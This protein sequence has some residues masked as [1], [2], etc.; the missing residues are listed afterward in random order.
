MKNVNTMSAAF[1]ATYPPRK[2]GIGTFTNDLVQ[3]LTH[4]SEIGAAREDHLKVIAMNDVA[5]GY[6]FPSEVNFV[7]REQ[8]KSDYL[9][10]A[11]FLNLS[12]VD[13]VSLQHEYGIFGGDDGSH[14]AYFLNNLRKPV[15]S[16]LHTML[17]KPSSGQKEILEA[18]ISMSTF[19]IVLANKA[20]EILTHVYNVPEEKIVMIPHGAPDVPFLDSSYYKDN[21]Q[22]ED[23]RVLLTFG[24]LNPNKGIE[25]MIDALP[26]IVKDFPDVLYIVLGATHPNVKREHG[27]KYRISL[28]RR[29]NELGLV[30]NV[31]F[32][33]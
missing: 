4:L 30:N 9:E 28:E 21:F 25:F 12:A 17:D 33:N 2:C 13:V 26:P 31:I 5:D 6:D 22:A 8:Y 20:I 3:S 15:V 24:L 10:A 32:H 16:T 27:E 11:E 29:V 7:I 1:I 19:V 23:R 14:I 18:I